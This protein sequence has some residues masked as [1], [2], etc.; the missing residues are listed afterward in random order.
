[1]P[2]RLLKLTKAV[3][4]PGKAAVP[5]RAAYCVRTP[6]YAGYNSGP[7]VRPVGSVPAGYN[8]IS[9]QFYSPYLPVLRYD[10]IC[11]P[12]VTA[13]PAVPSRVDYFDLVGWNAGARS[14]AQVPINGGF[15]CVLPPSPI[16]VQIG[17]SP[18]GFTHTYA[19]MTHSLVAR[20]A[21][22]TVV[23]RGAT[24][25]GPVAL[26]AAAKVEV[27]RVQGLV[28]YLVD[29]EVIYSSALPSSGE[30]Y[31]AA[32]LYSTV[33]Y[34]DSPAITPVIP[35]I[36]FSA[37]LPALVASISET[38]NY[39]EVSTGAMRLQ[40]EAKLERVRG[41]VYF[42]A[43]L[44]R[45]VVAISETEGFNSVNAGLAPFEF[46]ATLGA[47]EEMPSSMV[48]VIP[49]PVLSC[50]L[51]SGSSIAFEAEIQLAFVAADIELNRVDVEMPVRIAL[52][53]SE[54]YMPDGEVDGSDAM[55]AQDTAVLECA[56]LLIT[57]D[58]IEVD[59]IAASLVIVLELSTVDGLDLSDNAT[60]GSVVE[61]LAM[62]QIAVYGST[63][64]ARQ[65]ALQYA[66]NYMTGAL[67]RY[68]DFE[69]DGFTSTEGRTFAWRKDGLYRL[70]GRSTE[71]LDALVDFG[72]SDYADAHLKR[73]Q[74]AFV[75]VR[76]DGQCYVRMTA[77]DGVERIYKLVGEGNQKRAQLAK[78]VASRF[79]N[80]R[81]QITEAS[82]ATVDNVELELGVSQRRG[83]T[84]R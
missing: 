46:A 21:E 41:L 57:M 18:R 63:S 53:V 11:Y 26:P 14:I 60:L 65:Q 71:A 48:A 40:L 49:P 82:F 66:V 35:Q 51:L 27:R 9:L 22:V 43:R 68:R 24:V 16:G 31:G 39:T 12:A 67:S 83:F 30:V 61:M 20:R 47:P 84:R 56:M 70:G 69:F 1:M 5:Y 4:T 13:K 78:G 44:P 33:D 7:P 29:D 58:G 62:E 3:Y 72:A 81:L 23:E 37:E 6:V 38:D 79:F 34:V 50:T 59:S 25:F 42:D 64:A 15:S 74:T 2:N 52:T 28:S 76:T 77:D 54:P 73:V 19:S 55:Y 80:V 75:G 10:E 45:M 36:A 17:L 8:G 32:M